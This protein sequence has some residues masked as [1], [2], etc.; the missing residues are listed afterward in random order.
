[1]IVFTA[2]K[3]LITLML[4]DFLMIIEKLIPDIFL[5]TLGIKIEVRHGTLGIS[6][7]L[8]IQITATQILTLKKLLE[9]RILKTL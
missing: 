7:I 5:G 6:S 4:Q 1:V 9:S 8:N 2:V 3:T